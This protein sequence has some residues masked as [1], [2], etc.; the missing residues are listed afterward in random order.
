MVGKIGLEPTKPS[1]DSFTDCCNSPTLP[2]PHIGADWGVR[3]PKPAKVACFQDKCNYSIS[4]KS[5]LVIHERL[6][7][8]LPWLKVRCFTIKL[9]N[10]IAEENRQ[11]LHPYILSSIYVRT[12]WRLYMVYFAY[13]P[14]GNGMCLPNASGLLW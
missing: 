14:N 6:E 7:L 11:T 3:S 13:A 2:L 10:H 12:N 8:A 5:A 9:M 4:A 1:G